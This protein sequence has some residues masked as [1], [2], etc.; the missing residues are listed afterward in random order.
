MFYP[1]ALTTHLLCA[2]MFIGVV[3]FEIV[4]IEGIRKR[5][6]DELMERFENALVGRARK[7]M[8]YVVGLL[9]LSGAYLLHSHFGALQ[10]DWKNSFTVLLSIKIALAIS[11]LI[12]FVTALRAQATGCMSS[13]RF[14]IT[15]LSVGI[16]MLF[17]VILA[18]AMFYWTW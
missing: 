10:L 16:H 11:V 9:F 2:I 15:H 1:I 14:Q 7:V 13:R 3:F 18:K 6:G 12:H 8:P 5:I 17:I 4:M